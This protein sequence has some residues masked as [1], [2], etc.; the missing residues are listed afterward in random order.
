MAWRGGCSESADAE[1]WAATALTFVLEEKLALGLAAPP[2]KMNAP[3]DLLKE[4]ELERRALAEREERA[5]Q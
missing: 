2:E 3:W 1:I 4:T 5:G